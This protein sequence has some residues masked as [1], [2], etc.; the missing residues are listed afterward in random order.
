VTRN[1]PDPAR[2]AEAVTLYS[3]GLTRAQVAARMSVNEATVSRWLALMRPRGRRKRPD[4][5]DAVIVALRED[6]RT[7]REIADGVKMSR[8]GARKRYAAVKAQAAE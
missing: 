6:G 7:W 4:V 1:P 2:V 3:G 8:S 5:D